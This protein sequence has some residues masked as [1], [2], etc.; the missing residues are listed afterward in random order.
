MVQRVG[1][2]QTRPVDVRIVSATQR[3]LADEVEAGRFRA[4]L[5]FRLRA[6]RLKLPLL[7]ERGNDIGLLAETFVRASAQSVNRP[8]ERI[9]DDAMNCLYRY[10]SPGNVRELKNAIGHA[11]LACSGSTIEVTHL[12][13][14]LTDTHG[15]G[16]ATV[17]SAGDE[18]ERILEALKSSGGNRARAARL[19]GISRATL[20]RRLDTLDI[21][22]T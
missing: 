14:E 4:D 18:R 8:V 20:Y 3:N 7:R 9:S 21:D 13:P 22:E 15:A 12:P 5:L 11:V 6:A 17:L 2:T 1:E 10:G 19:L 16:E